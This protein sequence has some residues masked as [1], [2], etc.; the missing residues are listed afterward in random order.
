MREER[1]MDE[2]KKCPYCAEEIRAEAIKCRFCGERLDKDLDKDV[3]VVSTK[4][5]DYSQLPWLFVGAYAV[6][7]GKAMLAD[8]IGIEAYGRVDVTALDM[9]NNRWRAFL[10]TV[11]YKENFF[12][13]LNKSNEEKG[14][15]WFPTDE[16]VINSDQSV[17]EDEY[18]GAFHIGNE[19]RK[20][21]IQKYSKEMNSHFV[22]W[23][24]KLR[25]P[26]IYLWIIRNEVN[27]SIRETELKLLLEETNIPGL[28]DLVITS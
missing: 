28:K 14:Y 16:L 7:H 6:Y 9:K 11:T 10:Q 17:Q 25:W 5:N 2:F 13:K 12:G 21:I 3:S 4:V 1:K 23:D 22:Y 15:V 27:G 24:K 26:L 20:C 8:L 18:E 19:V